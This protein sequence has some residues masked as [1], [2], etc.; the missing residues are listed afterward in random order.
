[1]G[2]KAWSVGPVSLWVNW[3]VS[4]KAERFNIAGRDG[5]DEVFEWLNSKE[6]NLVIYIN[7]GSLTKF[8]ATQLREI[9][10]GLEVLLSIR[11][12]T[13]SKVSLL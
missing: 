5:H 12:Y 13:L 2:L 9:A 3:D 4:D 6:D 11:S 8:S 7:F 1:M 10:H